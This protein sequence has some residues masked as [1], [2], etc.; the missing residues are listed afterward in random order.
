[1]EKVLH[2]S[3]LNALMND[4]LTLQ[5]LRLPDEDS[6]TNFITDTKT[7]WYELG[8][9]TAIHLIQNGTLKLE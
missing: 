7:R 1:M 3:L 5:E 8:F 4:K 2:E 6:I 9:R